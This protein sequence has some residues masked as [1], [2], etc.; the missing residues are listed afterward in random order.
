MSKTTKNKQ[1]KKLQFDK[2]SVRKLDDK[3][4]EKSAGGYPNTQGAGCVCPSNNF[5]CPNHNQG[6]R[7]R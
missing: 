4:L 1:A 7:R 2:K 6:L 5:C 3:E